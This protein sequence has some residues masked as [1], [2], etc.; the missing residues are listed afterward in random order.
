MSSSKPS[1]KNLQSSFEHQKLHYQPQL[2][3]MCLFEP[4]LGSLEHQKFNFIPLLV[5]MWDLKSL[6]KPQSA[7]WAPIIF[8]E[9]FWA[10]I[11]NMHDIE[12]HI[13]KK[14]P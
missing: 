5:P 7:F 1:S 10:T 11:T 12:I 8:S 3:P 9:F 4:L 2:A 13:K 6:S 14:L